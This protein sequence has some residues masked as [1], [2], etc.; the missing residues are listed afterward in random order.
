MQIRRLTAAATLG[1]AALAAGPALAAGDDGQPKQSVSEYTSDAVVTTKV[2]A[3][4]V[5]EPSISAL[6][7]SVETNEG[8]VRLGGTVDTPEQ[9][10]TATRVARGVEGVRQVENEIKVKAP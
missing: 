9:S 10:D 7:I 8:V 3:A 5:A 6:Q 1:I 4:I 2:K